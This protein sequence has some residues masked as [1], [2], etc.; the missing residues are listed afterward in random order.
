MVDGISRKSTETRKGCHSVKCAI[1][2]GCD[3]IIRPYICSWL[4]DRV[5]WCYFIMYDCLHFLCTSFAD[6]SLH[7]CIHDIV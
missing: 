3:Y 1:Q 2:H 6:P 4:L 5:E 7:T